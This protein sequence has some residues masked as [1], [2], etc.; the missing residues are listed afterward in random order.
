MAFPVLMISLVPLRQQSLAGPLPNV[1]ANTAFWAQDYQVDSLITGGLAVEA[2]PGTVAP[3]AEP[4]YTV[5]GVPGL[6]AGTSNASH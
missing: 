5:N 1:P 4:P 3:P 2:P 6:A